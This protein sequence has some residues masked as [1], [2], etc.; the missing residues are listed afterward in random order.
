MFNEVIGFLYSLVGVVAL[1]GYMPQIITLWR[2][3]NPCRDVSVPTWAIWISTWIVSLV[4]GITAL[5]DFKFIMVALVNVVG[6]GLIIILTLKN[7]YVYR[8][9]ILAESGESQ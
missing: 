3:K 9:V 4:Y 8:D 2:A 1:I 7:R 6:H 5:G